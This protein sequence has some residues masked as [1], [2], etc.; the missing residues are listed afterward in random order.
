ME[1]ARSAADPSRAVPSAAA[2]ACANP[3]AA[4]LEVRRALAAFAASDG[5]GGGGAEGDVAAEARAAVRAWVRRLRDHRGLPPEQ[6]LIVVKRAARGA[7]APGLG[8]P[9]GART[10]E[11]AEARLAEVVRWCIEE[12]YG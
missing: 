12:Y 6:T 5:D 1:R 4:Q 9:V 11:Q 7:L 3:S 2:P 10:H 8:A